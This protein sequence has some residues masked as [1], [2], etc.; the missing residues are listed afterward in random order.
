M[1]LCSKWFQNSNDA[2]IKHPLATK[3]ILVAMELR[4]MPALAS[5]LLRPTISVTTMIIA[6]H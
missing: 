3:F 5:Q 1:C 6:S 4:R 2:Q